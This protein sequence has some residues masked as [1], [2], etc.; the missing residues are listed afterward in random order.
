MFQLPYEAALGGLLIFVRISAILFTLPVFG[1][2]PTPIRVRVLLS[3]ALAFIVYPL[4]MPDWLPVL[5]KGLFELVMVIGK[6]ILLGVMLGY[7]SRLFFDGI[8]MAASLVGYQ[9]GFGTANLLVPDAGIQMNAFTALHRIVLMLIFL[10]LNLHHQ[11]VGAITDSF[12]LIPCGLLTLNAPLGELFIT[13]TAGVFAVA[14]QL[15]APV[16]VALMFTMAALG[17]VARAVPQMNIFTMSFPT[18]F[19]IGLIIYAASLPYFPEM[20]KRG[21]MDS[22]SY[23]SQT[24]GWM[25]P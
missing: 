19:F 16:L 10:S 2:E 24:L 14:V 8:V 25:R 7:T 4:I 21:F 18:S 17:L 6:E 20:V 15:S 11:Y 22:Q 13:M 12:K 1:D 5:P 3:V 23:L 9:M